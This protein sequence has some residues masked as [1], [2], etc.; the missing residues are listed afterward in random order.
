MSIKTLKK[1]EHLD[2]TTFDNNQ[3]FAIK[4]SFWN[5]D[6]KKKFYMNWIF[7]NLTIYQK[8]II[9]VKSIHN[10]KYKMG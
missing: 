7:M 9:F 8:I 4:N 3:I 6:R 5:V 1:C 10:A 2:Y